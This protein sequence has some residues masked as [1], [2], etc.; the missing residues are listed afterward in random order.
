VRLLPRLLWTILFVMLS[1]RLS[2]EEPTVKPLK[3]LFPQFYIGTCLG[4]LLPD[5]FTNEEMALIDA[6]F[7]VVTPEGCMKPEPIQP[8]EGVFHFKYPDDLVAYAE[9]HGKRVTGHTLIWHQQCPD[10][11]FLDGNKPAS[12]ELVLRRL[13]THINT[14]VGRYRGQIMGWDVVNEAI[15]DG[16]DVYYRPTKWWKAIGDDYIEKAFEYAHEA[17]PDAELYY[18]DYS[19]ESPVK[20][21]KTLKLI[22]RLK[23]KG[24]RIDA[25]GI[26]GHWELD[27]VPFKD[28]EDAIVAFHNAGVKVMITELDLDVVT[29]WTPKDAPKEVANPYPNAC[30]PEVLQRQAEQYAK[31][32]EIFARHS[33]KITRVAFW[34]LHDGR[35]WLNFWPRWRMNYPLLFDRNAKPKPAFYAVQKVGLTP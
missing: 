29:R 26:Q 31:L 16:K 28:I 18:N 20:R 23:E 10:W 8:E 33:D 3:D 15:D 13:R 4:G 32:F 30:P 34:G 19:I 22:A 21:E 12:R 1:L 11:F 14:L 25:V 27:K 2:A 24:L 6:H 9:A 5:D 7:N 35:S 17:D